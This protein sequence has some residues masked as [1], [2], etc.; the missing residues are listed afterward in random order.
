MDTHAARELL[1]I[2]K[3][4]DLDITPFEEIPFRLRSSGRPRF[5]AMMNALALCMDSD[6]VYLEVGSYQGGS[7][8]G[9]LLGNKARAFAVED[10]REFYGDPDV[11]NTRATLERNLR[12]FGVF[13]RVALYEMDFH[14][15]FELRQTDIPPVPV[16]LYY[17]DAQHAETDTYEGLMLGFPFVVPGG[18][19]VL[20]DNGWNMVS[21]GINRFLGEHF[22]EVKIIFS[23]TA[24]D[25][26]TNSLD[27]D[28]WNGTMV[29]EKILGRDIE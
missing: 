13:D 28:W 5:H 2:R 23:T 1:T 25:S 16:G 6:E 8:I 21:R 22:N 9:T 27:E 26:G 12:A 17:Y 10:F 19:I 4:L 14:K 11:D 15:F 29:I 18:F 24:S 3:L 7:M 20:D